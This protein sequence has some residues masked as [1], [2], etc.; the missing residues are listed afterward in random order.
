VTLALAAECAALLQDAERA[1][2]LRAL[3]DRRRGQLLVVASGTSCEGA[4]DRYL[5]ALAGTGGDAAAAE[6]H[7]AAAVALEEAAGGPALAVRTRIAHARVLR[8][9]GGD[10]RRAE[11]LL[12]A[13]ESSAADLGLAGALAEASAVR[14]GS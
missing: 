9:P 3:L 6:D 12:D 13:A 4:V 10:R 7:F 2:L 14:T 8:G 5:G 1:A 11:A